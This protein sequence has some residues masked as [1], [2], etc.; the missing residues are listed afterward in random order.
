MKLIGY[1]KKVVKKIKSND[2][3]IN[4]FEVRE[5]G[6]VKLQEVIIDMD[7][8][9]LS[10]FAKFINKLSKDMKLG[11]EGNATRHFNGSDPTVADIQFVI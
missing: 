10:R 3:M 9:E 1:K 7:I 6:L 11:K 2:P 8:D 5:V 4:G